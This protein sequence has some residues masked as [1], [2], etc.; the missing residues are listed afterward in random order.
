MVEAAR[1]VAAKW[2]KVVKAGSA[3]RKLLEG[4]AGGLDVGMRE[5]SRES[6]QYFQ[7]ERL[8]GS[9]WVLDMSGLLC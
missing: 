6:H 9:I 3:L 4:F 2:W 5:R 1:A 8:D 7:P